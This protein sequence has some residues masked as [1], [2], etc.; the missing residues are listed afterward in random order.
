MRT[1]VAL[2]GLAAATLLLLG[3][4]CGGEGTEQAAVKAA[5]RDAFQTFNERDLEGFLG[6]ITD[7]FYAPYFSKDDIRRRV[8][9]GKF[10]LGQ[11]AVEVIEVRDIEIVGDSATTRVTAREGRVRS[12]ETYK[13]IRNGDTWLLD[14][15]EPLKVATPSGAV[16]VSVDLVEFG[17]ALSESTLPSGDIA[18]Q[19][20]NAGRQAHEMV[21]IRLL[22]GVSIQEALKAEDLAALGVADFGS[23][24]PVDPGGEAT[25]IMEA[26]EPGRYGY[27]CFL[28]DAEDPEKTPHAFK[29]MA[30]EF[31]VE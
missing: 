18:F 9:S 19:L 15:S 8:A 13:L 4:G 10:S 25:G 26:L 29:G 28:P 30:G 24:A 6:R 21:V 27:A 2:T 16:E 1:G 3:V 23:I 14:G 17:F 20:T 12:T 7:N 22:E 31:R 11:P 5:V